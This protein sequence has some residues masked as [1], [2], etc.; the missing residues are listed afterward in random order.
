MG[1]I[2]FVTERR[3]MNNECFNVGIS[4]RCGPDCPVYLKGECDEPEEMIERLTDEQLI[5]H[6]ELYDS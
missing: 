6:R 5:M 4:G 2:A 1:V 3:N